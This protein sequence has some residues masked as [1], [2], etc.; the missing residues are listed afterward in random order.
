[1]DANAQ[2]NVQSTLNSQNTQDHNRDEK[3]NRL[4]INSLI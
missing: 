3:D 1:M 4:F 2:Q